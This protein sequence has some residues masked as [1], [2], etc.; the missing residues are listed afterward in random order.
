MRFVFVVEYERAHGNIDLSWAF[1]E[2]RGLGVCWGALG[3]TVQCSGGAFK[4][5]AEADVA[6][7]RCGSQRERHRHSYPQDPTTKLICHHPGA[8][9]YFYPQRVSTH[10]CQTQSTNRLFRHCLQQPV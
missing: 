9:A 5:V 7:A 4:Y 8:D 3:H 10:L 2:C 1:R 6:R